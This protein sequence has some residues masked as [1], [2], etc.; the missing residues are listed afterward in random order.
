MTYLPLFL[1]ADDDHPVLVV[2]GGEIA[3]AKTEALASVGVRVDV[4]A[5]ELGEAIIDMCDDHG[6]SYEQGEYELRR[7]EGRRI[8]I[9]A[10]DD[11]ALNERIA[12]DCR[13]HGIL[14]NVVD[15]P[16]L[17]DF[18]FPALVRRGP[19]QVAV[20]TSG[21]APTLARMIKQTLETIVPAEF[22]RLIDFMEAQKSKLRKGLSQIQ[23]R[24]LFSED[25]IRGPIAEEVLEG[26]V[27]RAEE[28]FDEALA[29]YPDRHSPALYLVGTGPGNAD[30]VTLKAIRLLGQADVILY[31]RLAA[32]ELITQ[33]GRKDAEKIFVGKTRCHHH[34]KQ[35]EIDEIIERHLRDGHIVVRLKGGDPGIYG[36]AAEEI[37]IA[38]KVGVPYQIVPGISAAHGCAAYAGLPLTERDKALSVRFLTLYKDQLH[39]ETFWEGMQ[40]ATN[41]TLV[42][43]MSSH[44][45]GT[46]CEKLIENG[47]DADTRFLVIEQGTTPYQKEFPGTLARFEEDYADKKFA[48]PCLMIVGEVTRYYEEFKWKQPPIEDGN[49]FEDLPPLPEK[50]EKEAA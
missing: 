47:F 32:P 13:A 28:L 21:I 6:F 30:L 7:I 8:V 4:V 3:C 42:F 22:E 16:P 37:A 48:S 19:L 18:I 33:Y 9:A 50:D 17:C 49:F 24:R 34:K 38:K 25:V 40:Y 12:H 44:N 15:N 1:K 23:P 20:S 36:H 31:D 39:D 35:E 14:V 41:E 27:Q 2:G 10:T 46:L 43:Y 5:K 26:N 11:D 29:R 45:Y